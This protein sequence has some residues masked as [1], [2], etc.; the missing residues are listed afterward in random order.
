METGISWQTWRQEYPDGQGTVRCL[1]TSQ[2]ELGWRLSRKHLDSQVK[3]Q[4]RPGAPGKMS[5]ETKSKEFLT[6]RTV[7]NSQGSEIPWNPGMSVVSLNNPDNPVLKI[8]NVQD[9]PGLCI[10]IYEHLGNSNVSGFETKSE[11][12]PYRNISFRLGFFCIET[13]AIVSSQIFLYRNKN[14]FGSSKIFYIRTHLKI[15]SS[16]ERFIIY[17]KLKYS[18]YSK[19]QRNGSIWSKNRRENFLLNPKI[20]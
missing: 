15:Y 20:V 9:S 19:L 5:E 2:E 16:P 6:A 13:K 12:F 17:R 4:E 14:I 1:L 8:S 18:I 10:Y 3:S 7:R 11:M